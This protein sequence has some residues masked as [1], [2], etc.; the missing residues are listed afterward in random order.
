M[1]NLKVIFQLETEVSL[2]FVLTRA[3]QQ[4]SETNTLE[5]RLP[6][7]H[8]DRKGSRWGPVLLGLSLGEV[9]LRPESCVFFSM[10]TL[11]IKSILSNVPLAFRLHIFNQLISTEMP[12]SVHLFIWLNFYF[13]V[14]L[15]VCF[16]VYLCLSLSL[17]LS[18]R[19]CVCVCVFT[20]A[21]RWCGGQK[22]TSP[23]VPLE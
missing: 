18:L 1:E 12:E 3:R 10:L 13:S 6:K 20:C 19:V 4:I 5:V 21:Y 7:L 23:V 2:C 16:S 17:W 9:G 8:S 11:D 14:C 15:S 22:T